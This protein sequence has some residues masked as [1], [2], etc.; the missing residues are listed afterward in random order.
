MSITY[1][2]RYNCIYD[3]RFFW[4]FYFS[5]FLSLFVVDFQFKLTAHEA[6]HGTWKSL[7]IYIFIQTSGIFS[8]YYITSL[9]IILF[10]FPSSLFSYFRKN[11]QFQWFLFRN[12]FEIETENTCRYERNLTPVCHLGLFLCVWFFV[13]VI[14]N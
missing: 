8:S 3:E 11:F 9:V 4:F 6:S 2:L 1:Y 14:Y 7:L 5:S 13:L 10:F 12:F